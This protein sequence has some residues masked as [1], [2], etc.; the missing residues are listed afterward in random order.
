MINI[1]SKGSIYEQEKTIL[2]FTSRWDDFEHSSEILN[3]IYGKT[4]EELLDDLMNAY[5]GECTAIRE[6]I[7]KELSI[8]YLFHKVERRKMLQFLQ[9]AREERLSI[10]ESE[11][12]DFFE[13]IITKL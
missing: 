3:Q 5:N 10:V 9:K 13:R 6:F 2:K 1:F 11:Q 4:K 7:I 12:L 8:L